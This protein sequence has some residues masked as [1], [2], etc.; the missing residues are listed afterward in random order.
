MTELDVDPSDPG[1]YLST[2]S[3]RVKIRVEERARKS[4]DLLNRSDG[5]HQNQ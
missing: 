1:S 4:G 3:R 2:D 5:G